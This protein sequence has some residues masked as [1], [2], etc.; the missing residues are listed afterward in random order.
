MCLFRASGGVPKPLSAS[1]FASGRTLQQTVHTMWACASRRS[2]LA[3]LGR[4][5]PSLLAHELQ[6][7]K[8]CW[9]A[10]AGGAVWS[11]RGAKSLLALSQTCLLPRS[12]GIVQASRTCLVMSLRLPLCFAN[13]GSCHDF[14][15]RYPTLARL[16]AAGQCCVKQCSDRRLDICSSRHLRALS[17]TCQPTC[18][19]PL[20]QLAH[21]LPA[22]TNADI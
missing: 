20:S 8:M 17:S 1:A 9:F 2:C 7:S 15:C 19:R 14:S 22:C 11:D 10:G 5:S 18:R 21:M 16:H 13:L 4:V 3:Q 6:R 12:M